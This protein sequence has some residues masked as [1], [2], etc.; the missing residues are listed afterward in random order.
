MEQDKKH[1][2]NSLTSIALSISLF[3]LFQLSIFIAAQLFPD[4]FLG[5][6]FSMSSTITIG[7]EMSKSA[8]YL[9]ITQLLG[10]IVPPILAKLIFKDTKYF[11]QSFL[12]CFIQA[13]LFNTLVGL[14]VS[15]DLTLF[16]KTIDI[17]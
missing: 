17:L 15:K 11:W 4:Y 13:G 5:W 7:Q 9:L 1:Y 6:S 14:F 3:W 12:V 10:L 16:G 2:R 8:N